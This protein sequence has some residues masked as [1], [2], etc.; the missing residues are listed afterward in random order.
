MRLP[1]SRD[2]GHLEVRL[3]GACMERAVDR[4][5]KDRWLVV[6]SKKCEENPVSMDHW[7]TFE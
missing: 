1:F 3:E 5:L 7:R 4:F 2:Q 6:R